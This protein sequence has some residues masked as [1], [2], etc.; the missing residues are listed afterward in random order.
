MPV[1][2]QHRITGGIGYQGFLIPNLDL[3]LFAGGLFNG[4]DDFG[5]DTHTSLAMYYAGVGMTWRYGD[6][7][8]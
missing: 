2:N 7:S 5:A 1:V 4:G 3:D 8:R 6:C